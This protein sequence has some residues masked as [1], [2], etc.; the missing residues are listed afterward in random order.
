MSLKTLLQEERIFIGWMCLF[1]AS[2]IFLAYLITFNPLSPVILLGL[3]ILGTLALAINVEYI[4][5]L[6]IF[7]V[8]LDPYRVSFTFVNLSLFRLSLIV[9]MLNFIFK[10]LFGKVKIYKNRMYPFLVLHLFSTILALGMGNYATR[11]Q[12]VFFITLTGIAMNIIFYNIFDSKQK[13]YKAVSAFLASYA[14]YV[15]FAIYTYYSFVILGTERIGFPFTN[16]IPFDIVPGI[17]GGRLFVGSTGIFPR[18]H[19]PIGSPPRLSMILALGVIFLLGLI[20]YNIRSKGSRKILLTYVS[21]ALVLTA[22]VVLTMAR[23]G[24]LALA[25]GLA[26]LIF[27]WKSELLYHHV[28]S[29]LLLGFCVIIILVM[30]AIVLAGPSQIIIERVTSGTGV[31][32]HI[33]TRLEALTI[34]YTNLKTMLFGVGLSNYQFYS[35]SGGVHSHSAYT[36]VL[37]ERGLIGSLMYWPLYFFPFLFLCLS[38]TARSHEYKW[39]SYKRALAAALFV[40]IFGSLFY[41]FMQERN[42]WVVIGLAGAAVGLDRRSWYAT[43]RCFKG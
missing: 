14:I 36:T 7:L 5:Y 32:R 12:T 24:W 6:T 37:A 11:T 30:V 27:L 28:F 39:Q 42:M 22:M 35:Y 25:G 21:F 20:L 34:W 13:L 16:L 26:L 8:P 29:K 10:V 18:L 40:V 41:E 38:D 31:M 2:G 1:I 43:K 15:F 23:S 33:E 4:A 3:V 19:L 9:L 17:A